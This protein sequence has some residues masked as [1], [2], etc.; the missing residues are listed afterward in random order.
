M[1]SLRRRSEKDLRAVDKKEGVNEENIALSTKRKKS[2][3]DLSTVKW[4]AC[5]HYGHYAS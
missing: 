2:E 5:N 1:I 4:F 3:K